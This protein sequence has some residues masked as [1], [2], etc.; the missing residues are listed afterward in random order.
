MFNLEGIQAGISRSFGRGTLLAK[1]YS[2]EILLGAGLVGMLATVVMASKATLKAG[3]I[4]EEANSDLE[5]IDMAV[6][7]SES[8][9]VEYT[10]EDQMKDK[11]IVYVQTGLKF[12]QLYGPAVGMGVLSIA[13]ILASHGVMKNR[14]V[15][16]VAAYNLLNEGY[17][18]YRARVVEELG[19]EV[20]RNYHLGLKDESYSEKETDE[21]GKTKTVKGI[22]QTSY[23]NRT[24]SI[25]ARF[26]D[27]TSRMWRN[28]A[29]MNRAFLTA[30][31]RYMNDILILRGYLFL[32]EVYEALGLPWTKEGQL[33]G[34]V[35]K[36]DPKEMANE[37]RDGYVSF[38]I[39]NVYNDPG[40][41][42]VNGT[43]P[44]ILLDFNVD[45][46]VYDL[47]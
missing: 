22:R 3:D 39:F 11:A 33:V 28:D 20:D 19:A 10:Q 13:A 8:Q 38:D 31:E 6:Q 24:K 12:A 9:K 47:I 17:K 2:P 5:K 41:D 18:N 25:Y 42:F 21:E 29:L 45:G 32:N 40:R 1:K 35:L 14:Q 46:P 44:S 36:S 30:Q 15:A 37:G 34:W 7:V 26:F 23:D 43:N 4:L 27:E 16:L